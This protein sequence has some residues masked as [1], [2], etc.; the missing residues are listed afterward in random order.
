MGA[1]S[2]FDIFGDDIVTDTSTGL[3]WTK[4]ASNPSVESCKG[5][6]KNYNGAMDYVKCLNSLNYLGYNDWRMPT[7]EESKSLFVKDQ[8]DMKKWLN[9]QGFMFL[10]REL[11]DGY[12]TSTPSEGDVNAV[13][14]AQRMFINREVTSN[15][16]FELVKK[17]SY[18]YILLVRSGK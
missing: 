5:G 14:C 3:M 9:E 18:R 8:P 12:W 11:D 15:F 4:D 7:L 17:G 6:V 2:W 16:S 10:F 13:W 1:C